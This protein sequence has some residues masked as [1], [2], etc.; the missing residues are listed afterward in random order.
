MQKDWR[1]KRG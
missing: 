1:S